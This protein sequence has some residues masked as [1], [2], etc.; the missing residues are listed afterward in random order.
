[1][2]E[3]AGV[4]QVV[5]RIPQTANLAALLF[6]VAAIPF[7]FAAP[8]L[9]L[10]YLLPIAVIVWV[11][12]NRTVADADGLV[13]RTTFSRRSLP[14]DQLASLKLGPRGSVSAVGTDDTVT[15]LPGV[16]VRHLS[17]LSAV[18]GGRVPDPGE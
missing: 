7:A 12:R 13:T 2:T 11:V 3:T 14:W 5:F 15:K 16:K 6:A 17:L 9:W 10:V 1:V 4:K 8:L 18:S